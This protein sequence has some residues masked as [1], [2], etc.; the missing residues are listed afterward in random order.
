MDYGKEA[1]KAYPYVYIFRCDNLT[2]KPKMRVYK[3]GRGDVESRELDHIKT[4]GQV[5]LLV[6]FKTFNSSSAKLAE[7]MFKYLCELLEWKVDYVDNDGKN[8]KELFAIYNFNVTKAKELLM[9]C[10]KLSNENVVKFKHGGYD[11]NYTNLAKQIVDYE[12]SKQN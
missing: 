7:K 10:V 4:Y 5:T 12:L 8:R 3:F 1:R 9:Y 6:S 11:I 2:H